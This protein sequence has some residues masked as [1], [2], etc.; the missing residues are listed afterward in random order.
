MRDKILDLLKNSEK[1]LDVIEISNHLDLDSVSE[2]TSLIDVL[3]SLEEEVKIYKTKKDKYMLFEN[4]HL[5]VGKIH[6]NKKGF[7]F[8]SVEGVEDD[9]YIEE[10]NINY[11]LNGD[12]VVIEEIKGMGKKHEARVVKILRKENNIVIGEYTLK[13]NK[14]YFKLDDNKLKMEVILDKEDIDKL[15][16]GDKIQ[17][18]IDKELGKNK[19]LGKLK[20]I[21]GHKE[22]PGVDILSIVY[23]YDINDTFPDK[24][25]EELDDIPGEVTKDDIKNRRNL[26]NETIFTID[27]DD[28]KDIDDAV[29]ISKNG[30]NYILGV[31]IADVS[32]YVK[33]GSELYKEAM[34]RGTSVYLVDRVIPMLPHKLSNGICSLN[35]NEDRLAISCVME[36]NPKGKVVDYD[37]FESVIRSR[38]QMTYN[39]VNKVLDGETPEDYKEFENDLRL[40]E[41]LANI[42]RNEKLAR[43]YLD[44][45][46]KEA[47]IIC[48]EKG[49][50]IEIKLRERGKGENL[51]EDFMIAANETV[52]SHLFN[53]DYPS[54]YRV[55]E[56]PDDK[57]I[58]EFI[59]AISM[60][61]IN[62]KGDRNY[63]NPMKLKRILDELREREDFDVLSNLM[64][65]S[66]RKAEYKEQ[67]L[68]HYGLGSK[69][70]THF[71][72]PIR[73]FPDTTIHKLLREY[74]FNTPTPNKLNEL[75]DKYNNLLPSIAEHSSLKERNAIEC[76]RD[77]D[78]MKM[79]EYMEGHVGEVFD[80]I[81]DSIMNFGM[82]V[83]LDNTIEGLVSL[84]SLKDDYYTFNDENNT[85]VGR[86]RGKIY[87]IGDKVKVKVIM[88]SKENSMIDFEIVEG[89]KNGNTK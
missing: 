4:S 75:I 42:L 72:S 29:S 16:Q 19:Y 60:L 69:C 55:H 2:M 50:P 41:E 25:M 37:I 7:G 1:A 71:T 88:A 6:I 65:R 46:A 62:I 26:T 33:E 20:R 13:N 38:K 89:D 84:G 63:D 51:I 87:K 24:V 61:G 36:I 52:A 27:G 35:P 68:G 80:G 49:K 14:P 73:R 78:D 67:N 5:L 54:I 53:L 18:Y 15:I 44:F 10:S 48:D 66:L 58:N 8:V 12:L 22:D 74:I 70:Y 79:A 17:V 30:D 43:G 31:H 76:E 9:F 23:K 21:I 32:Y 56:V 86:K 81:I 85:L 11:A 64:L 57:K 59:N 77:V 40:M 47:K 28:T 82:F 83:E 45:D 3:N 39:N 34:D